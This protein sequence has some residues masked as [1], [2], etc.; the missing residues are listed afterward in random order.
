MLINRQICYARRNM[1]IINLVSDRFVVKY[2]CADEGPFMHLF[3]P[4]LRPLSNNGNN[5][6]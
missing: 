1:I 3:G 2:W 4:G 6:I 5:N